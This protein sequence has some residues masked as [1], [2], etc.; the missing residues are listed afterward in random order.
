MRTKKIGGGHLPNVPCE[1]VSNLCKFA[2]KKRHWLRRFGKLLR[3]G[4]ECIWID[5]Q[6]DAEFKKFCKSNFDLCRIRSDWLL[7]FESESVKL[8]LIES[9]ICLFTDSSV[10]TI[11]FTLKSVD[12]HWWISENNIFHCQISYSSLK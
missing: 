9:V 3:I 12:F 2:S 8:S 11:F 10:G 7:L 6:R 5:I 4:V 1:F